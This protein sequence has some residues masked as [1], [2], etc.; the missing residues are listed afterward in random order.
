[1]N[2]VQRRRFLI[3]AGALLASPLAR[4]QAGRTY[5]IGSVYL[6]A[7]STTKPYDEAFLGGLRE[8]G[9]ERGKNLVYDVRNCDGNPSRLPGAVDELIALK[10]D[11]LAGIEQVAKVMRS[12]TATIPIVL[13]SSTDPVAAGL[14]KTLA[15]PGGNVTGM[16]ALNEAMAAKSV[17]ILAEIV[18]QMKTVGAI[19]DPNVPAFA[20]IE[21][22]VQEAA[23]AKR[24]KAVFYRARD[25]AELAQAFAAM[26]RDRPDGIVNSSGSGTLFG[27]RQFIAEHALRLRIP[28]A[29][30]SLAAVEAGYLF[31]YSASLSGTYRRA[32]SHAARILKG[33][34]PAEIPIEQPTAFELVINMKTAKALGIAIPRTVL[35]RA[36]RVIE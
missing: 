11:L 10:P 27:E 28:S 3:A 12:K 35:L 19:I 20:N 36:D 30:A 7:Y 21:R 9:F 2:P 5:R 4:A 33:A 15:R 18:P 31:A 34:N 25:R 32:A 23:Q 14:A 1:M 16:A 29:A 22:H 26:E 6:A 17:E 24:A 13:T 8:L